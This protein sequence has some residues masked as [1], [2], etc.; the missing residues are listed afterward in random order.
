VG[1][2]KPDVRPATIVISRN[3]AQAVAYGLGRDSA[4]YANPYTGEVR[5]PAS[6]KVHDFLHVLEDWHR[7]LAMG[8][9]NRPIGKAING[10]C[11][12][13]FCFLAVS[14]LWLWWPRNWSW[15]GVK[16]VAML[17]W[18][19]TGKAR[20]FN[21]HNAI[22]LWSAPILIVLTLTAMPIS[23]RWAGNAVYKLVGEEPPPAPGQPPAVTP[24]AA[25]TA[26][27]GSATSPAAVEIK[28]PAPDARPLSHD[29]L[30]SRVQQQYPR[31]ES[32]TFRLANPQRGGG[33]SQT[34]ARPSGQ[35]TPAP[36]GREGDAGR[37]RS[38]GRR[39]GDA[40]GRRAPQPV[41]IIVKETG[42]WP[43]TATTTLS[44]NP[45]TG[46]SL[47][48]EG[49]SDLSPGRQIRGWMRFLHTG[50]ALGLGGQLFAGLASLGGC[51]LV[52][53]GFAL[54]WRRFVKKSKPATAASPA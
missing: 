16:A 24:P 31:W 15:A 32:I 5:S 36:Q 49:F 17:N 19:L 26:T 4:V 54:A 34:A 39:E 51:F 21:W 41:T 35:A 53:T 37:P 29:A 23:Y 13:A 38:E 28:R 27:A 30:L 20:D 44:L 8:G 12:I 52:Y 14:G 18:R 1:E 3:P 43:R 2:F 48:T 9:D 22:G 40:E 42:T 46:E 10:A 47:K 45:F 7:V 25:P 33:P 50:E 11:N 6:T